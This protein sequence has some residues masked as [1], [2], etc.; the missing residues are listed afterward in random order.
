MN[1]I[2]LA[3]ATVKAKKKKTT[4][5]GVQKKKVAKIQLVLYT[6]KCFQN[7]AFWDS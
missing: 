1:T 3:T 5:E 2:L 6:G 7:K 4:K